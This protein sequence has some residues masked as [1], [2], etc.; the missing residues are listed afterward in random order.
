M[1]DEIKPTDNA[2]VVEDNTTETP[3]EKP[4]E[5]M[6]NIVEEKKE[7][8]VVPESTFLEMKNENKSLKK[9][10]ADLKKLVESGASKQEVSAS[11]SELADQYQVDKNFL[12]GLVTA[13]KQE[14]KQEMEEKL[15]PMQEKEKRETF[16]K[17]F[18]DKFNEALEEMPEFK[19]VAD[20][21]VIKALAMRPEN[22][23]K[24]FE[25]LLEKAYGKFVTREKKTL[26]PNTPNGG[27]DVGV[28][29]QKAQT[30][31]EY[32]K[33]IMSNPETKKIYNEHLIKNFRF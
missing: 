6:E 1:A 14:A 19:T 31:K 23:D 5:T 10:M 16:D 29:F 22:K 8:R 33:Q 3:Q 32:F 15:K 27:K 18:A 4:K 7:K 17:K 11:I 25:D 12:T 28:D 21:E 24:T 2:P 26:E 30:D 13:I 9:E 20:M